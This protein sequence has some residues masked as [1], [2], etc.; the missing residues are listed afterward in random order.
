M[1]FLSILYYW[2]TF[3]KMLEPELRPRLALVQSNQFHVMS[4]CPS[5]MFPSRCEYSAFH[6]HVSCTVNAQQPPVEAGWGV[7]PNPKP[8]PNAHPE[9]I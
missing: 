4:L 6:F 8:N 7:T 5:R 1:S 3:P 9:L 2:T